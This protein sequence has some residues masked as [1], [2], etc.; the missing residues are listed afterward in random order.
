MDDLVQYAGELGPWLGVAVALGAA[1]R[2]SQAARQ[3]EAEASKLRASSDAVAVAQLR[4]WLDEL[5]NTVRAQAAK[6]RRLEREATANEIRT[7]DLEEENARL[8]DQVGELE[9][10]LG[11][12][13]RQRDALRAERDALQDSIAA[14]S[15]HELPPPPPVPGELRM[16]PGAHRRKE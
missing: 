3:A 1:L 16:L 12:V 7:Q 10:R 5:R 14:S 13:E 9:R 2:S 6:I 8:R 11:E 4:T 15:H